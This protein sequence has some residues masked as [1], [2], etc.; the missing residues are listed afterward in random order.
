METVISPE[1]QLKRHFLKSRARSS[2]TAS[3]YLFTEL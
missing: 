3:P 1:V 2:T